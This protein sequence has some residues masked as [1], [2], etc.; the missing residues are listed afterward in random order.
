MTLSYIPFIIYRG[1][2]FFT[3]N[4]DD[5]QQVHK[6]LLFRRCYR[7]QHKTKGDSSYRYHKSNVKFLRNPVVI[8]QHTFCKSLIKNSELCSKAWR[9][10][11]EKLQDTSTD[12]LPCYQPSPVTTMDEITRHRL[13]RL[14]EKT[15]VP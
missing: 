2:P 10:T 7:K 9:K 13:T 4:E 11:F 15:R 8:S 14:G 3:D 6:A 12:R 1:N 5:K